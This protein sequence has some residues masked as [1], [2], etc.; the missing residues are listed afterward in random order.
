[1]NRPSSGLSPSPGGPHPKETT[2]A[3]RPKNA[4]TVDLEDWFHSE[5]PT[6][7]W[8]DYSHR[9][10]P[11]LETLIRLF[12][13]H[14]VRATF[15]VLGHVAKRDP[16]LVREIARAGH[17][18]AA[19]GEGHDF[20][21]RQSEQE[22]SRDVRNVK[23]QLEQI[24]SKP[25]LGYRAPFFSITCKS[26]WAITIL[27][28]HGYRYDSSIFP[29]L[30]HRYGIRKACRVPHRI[31]L[32]G[33][34]FIMEFPP[35]TLKVLRQNLPI[36]GGVYFRFFPYGIVRKGFQL[37]N[38]QGYPG[39][40]YIH[41]WEVD[42]YQPRLTLAPFLYVRRYFRL[43]SVK[44]KLSRFLSEFRFGTIAELYREWASDSEKTVPANDS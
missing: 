12:D 26:L 17:E 9:L 1:M 21:Y 24:I 8:E 36:S 20:V 5:R 10:R 6:E 41:A 23:D 22:F 31:E 4:M 29:V 35:S 28:E 2:V 32:P 14:G 30:N 7:R 13:H 19:H 25:V 37:L 43:G 44:A 18:I 3:K 33:G 27:R 38:Q 15:F 34:D 39:I 11:S 16:G 42:P 40:F